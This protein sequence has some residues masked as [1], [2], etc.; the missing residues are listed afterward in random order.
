MS[1]T[2][3]TKNHIPP[4]EAIEAFLATGKGGAGYHAA[5]ATLEPWGG[6]AAEALAH[7]F[8]DETRPQEVREQAA[9]PLRQIRGRCTRRL[10]TEA[11]L[12]NPDEWVRVEAVSILSSYYSDSLIQPMLSLLQNRRN[13][14][15][16]RSE[17]AHTLGMI[18]TPF[19][20]TATYIR[21]L[22]PHLRDPAPEVRLTVIY[23]ITQS[24]KARNALNE[25]RKLVN[26]HTPVLGW[27][28]MVAQEA[29]WAI[30]TILRP[31]FDTEMPDHA[32]YQTDEWRDK[33][34]AWKRQR[35]QERR[36]RRRR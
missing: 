1:Q 20:G 6:E 12:Y 19:S 36:K 18:H 3:L 24:R 2:I 25:I 9:W 16:L 13:S 34:E 28:W 35:T 17:A 26:D 21:A 4:G 11:A 8:L 32:M 27:R 33:I 7:I 29:R 5:I 31:N 23:A 30:Y 15:Q 14:S 22:I 10:L